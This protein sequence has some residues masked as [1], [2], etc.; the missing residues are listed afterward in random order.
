MTTHPAAAPVVVVRG[1]IVDCSPQTVTLRVCGKTAVFLRA[2]VEERRDCRYAIRSSALARRPAMIAAI[3]KRRE[4][5]AKIN[6]MRE[7]RGQ[8]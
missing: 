8:Q 5:V 4:Q 3:A 2:Q 6:A 1:E 7:A